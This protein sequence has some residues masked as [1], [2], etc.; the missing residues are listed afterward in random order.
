MREFVAELEEAGEL[1]SVE[2]E[3]DWDLEMGAIARRC[4]ETGA[5]AP[6]FTNVKGAQ[7]GFR[8]IGAPVGVS[9]RPGRELG[10][11][12]LALGL[13]PTASAREIVEVLV[14]ARG[15]PPIA[16]V[17]VDSGPCKQHVWRDGGV[18]LTSLPVPLLHAGDG[19]RYLNTL[20]MVVTRTPDRRWTSWAVARLMLLDERRAAYLIAPFQHTGRVFQEWRRRGEDMPVAVALGV[21]P[22]AL[23]AAGM[24]LPA[25]MDEGG[26]AGAL[27]GAPLEVVRCESVELEVPA[28]SEIVLEGRVSLEKHALE[29]PFG[30]YAGYVSPPVP[31]PAP[32]YT[33]EAM[34]FRDEP[35]YPFSCSGEPP[36]ETHTVWGVATVAEAVHILRD[37]GIPVTTAWS[38]FAAA[39]GWLVVTV[40]EGWRAFEPDAEELCRMVGDVVLATKV[41]VAIN[42]I[43]VCED[44]IDPA[45]LPEL[46]WAIDGRRNG[47]LTFA[48]KLGFP[49]SPYTRPDIADFPKGWMSTAEVWNLLPPEG[50]TRPPRARF[51]DNYPEWLKDR[52]RRLWRDDGF[53]D[54][55]GG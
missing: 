1:A 24:P 53:G 54:G 26:Y 21:P 8:A 47:S 51:E 23:Y 39:N 10:R 29:G 35:I 32:I 22:V 15:R 44:D 5:P 34:T 11:I 18:D 45:N 40:P 17:V 30:D 52:V 46:V 20:G 12:G 2:R 50:V 4:Y 9:R 13:P 48:D 43:I 33:V 14:R 55:L 27:A 37:R 41:R 6:L 38:P 36:D 28:D 42:T 49:F 16:P 31:A 7:A 3:V 19:G 25:D